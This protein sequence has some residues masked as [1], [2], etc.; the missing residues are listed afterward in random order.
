[1]PAPAPAR[2]AMKM[3]FPS[4]AY[5]IAGGSRQALEGARRDCPEA[6]AKAGDPG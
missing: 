3:V 1:M 2:V 5:D 6:A 4:G